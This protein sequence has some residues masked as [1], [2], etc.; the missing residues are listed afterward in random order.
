MQSRVNILVAVQDW[1][2]IQ[3]I[4]QNL[5]TFKDKLFNT[6]WIPETIDSRLILL[7]NNMEIIHYLIC[8]RFEMLI[9]KK[10]KSGLSQ[11]TKEEGA[12]DT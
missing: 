10:K 11:K 8:K 3:I 9:T 1:S 5:I 12:D 2:N 4:L 6:Y 7:T